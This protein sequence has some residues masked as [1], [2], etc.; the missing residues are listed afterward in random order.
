MKNLDDSVDDERLRK[1]FAPFGT[2][3][4][5]RVMVEEGRSK[6]M[7]MLIA[8]GTLIPPLNTFSRGWFRTGV[9]GALNSV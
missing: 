1:E 7:F 9:L 2:I 5:A 8:Q 6:G 4:S 3:T